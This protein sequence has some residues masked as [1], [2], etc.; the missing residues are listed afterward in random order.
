ML[1]LQLA[2]NRQRKQ[3]EFYPKTA[4]STISFRVSP[5]LAIH[6]RKTKTK[7]ASGNLT[8]WNWEH[9]ADDIT[10]IRE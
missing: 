6:A 10:N 4:D 3:E 1:T 5:L 9:N 8:P 2:H 7:D